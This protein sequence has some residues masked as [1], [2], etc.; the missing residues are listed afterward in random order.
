MKYQLS[1]EQ[2][3]KSKMFD[4]RGK[5]YHKPGNRF[6]LFPFTGNTSAISIKL[7]GIM[8]TLPVSSLIC[9]IFR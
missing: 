8:W 6:K 3:K 4:S 9:T 7:M 2:F 1:V 5:L